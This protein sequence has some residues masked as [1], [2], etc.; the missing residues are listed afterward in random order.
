MTISDNIKQFEEQIPEHVKLVAV[1]K[2]KPVEIILEAYNAGYR[3]FGENK[4]QELAAKYP[5]LPK[6][7]EWHFVGHMQT[8]KVKYIAQFVSLIHAV[9][10]LK[11]LK[12]IN[13]QALKYDRSIDC[14]LQFHI[15]TEQTKYGLNFEEAE[16]I[17]Q[18][19]EYKSLKNVQLKGVMGMGTFTNDMDQVRQEFR[20]L[21]SYFNK[22]RQ[23]HFQNDQN[24]KELSMGMTGD[25]KI[26]IE[27]GSTIIRIGTAIFGERYR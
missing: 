20:Q 16:Q 10:S 2:T 9:D 17:L 3:I 1:S 14:L 8:N 27:E 13:K 26:A 18:S 25:Y 19:D 4:I 6:D 12:E 15:A 23:N 24:F 5:E 21:K 22:I 7:I 11:L